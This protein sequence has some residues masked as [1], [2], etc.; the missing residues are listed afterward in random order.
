LHQ[1]RGGS[2]AESFF[3]FIFRQS[4]K[5]GDILN[6]MNQNGAAMRIESIFKNSVKNKPMESIYP[7]KYLLHYYSI[8][9]K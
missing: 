7:D 1:G 5:S 6:Y 2:F 3:L 8:M 9:I 4:D